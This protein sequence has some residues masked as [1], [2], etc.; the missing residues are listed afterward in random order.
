[1]ILNHWTEALAAVIPESPEIILL[2][3]LLPHD[4]LL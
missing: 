3:A 1:M 4:D 2:D